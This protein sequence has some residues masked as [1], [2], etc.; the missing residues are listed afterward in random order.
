MSDKK[1]HL[2]L[3]AESDGR[4]E[5]QLRGLPTANWSTVVTVP[6]AITSVPSTRTST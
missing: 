1:G 4:Q 5:R 2:H 6:T 3:Q